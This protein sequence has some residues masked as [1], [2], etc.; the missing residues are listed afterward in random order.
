MEET[1]IGRYVILKE[2]G[3]GGQS[4][5]YLARDPAIE[6][7]VAIKQIRAVTE[8][9]EEIRAQFVT[10]F[11]QEA[12]VA[13][14]LS[15]PNI[16]SIYDLGEDEA[17]PYIVM[18]FVDGETLDGIIERS[19]P[20]DKQTII[21][22]FLQICSGLSFA[23]QHEVVHRDVKPA[24]IML[25]R[26]GLVKLVD[27][28]VARVAST[29]LTQTGTLLGTPSYMSPEQIRG[30]KVDQRSDIFSLG[31]VLYEVLTG[32]LPFEGKNP[33]T[34]IFRIVNDP[35]S[36]LAEIN[37]ALAGDFGSI[38]DRCLEKSATDR[39][40]D[41]RELARDLSHLHPGDSAGENLFDTTMGTAAAISTARA[42]SP[43]TDTN[44]TWA[45]GSQETM[46]GETAVARGEAEWSLP[47]SRK[48]LGLIGG[49]AAAVLILVA[50]LVAANL[51]SEDPESLTAG[52]EVESVETVASRQELLR[53]ARAALEAGRLVGKEQDDALH[54]AQNAL[55]QGETTAQEVIDEVQDRF[56]EQTLRQARRKAPRVAAMAYEGFLAY[57]PDD[58]QMM[59]LKEQMQG[60][61]AQANQLRQVEN[62]AV[63]GQSALAEGN[64]D[65]AARNF[66]RIL[67]AA[68]KDSYAAHML[69]KTH[70]AKGDLASARRYLERAVS[71]SPLDPTMQMDL[72]D[73]L[74]RL[75]E[76]DAAA[77][78]IHRAIRLGATEAAGTGVLEVRL[79]KLEVGKE[80]S[81]LLPIQ[82]DS[83]HVHFLRRSC[84]GTLTVTADSIAYKPDK[85]EDHAF[86][87][88]LKDLQSFKAEKGALAISGPDGKKYNF[89]DLAEETSQVL[90]KLQLLLAEG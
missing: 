66:E 33:T 22:I 28:G 8:L 37:A 55:A 12:Q 59:A 41:C 68:P 45:G 65:E 57:F 79:A 71:L 29:N 17:G 61:I 26:D 86:Q 81:S 74:E 73:V 50:L 20:R 39:Y 13:G 34:M 76:Y 9:P 43:E 31:I 64:L 25:T 69:G 80:L 67:R 47:V 90:D 70:A 32:R 16:V 3:R 60:R 11:L 1:Q 7:T 38:I 52:S 5:V 54:L 58:E 88:Q 77:A 87:F 30:E 49:A 23:H 19:D 40:Q 72:A 85:N 2:I 89:D 46:L 15:H 10:R 44:A 53:E 83:K 35:H 75:E 84:R 63:R 36:P 78:A 27:F 24:N 21:P 42:G 51:G 6:R 48:T 82:S 18:E 56:R 4:R 14:T 62:L